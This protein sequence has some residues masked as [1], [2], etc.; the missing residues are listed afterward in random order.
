MLPENLYLLR[1][2]EYAELA[3]RAQDFEVR[4][5][6]RRLSACWLRLADYAKRQDRQPLHA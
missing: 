1:A 6:L 3:T 4:E 2:L 5:Q